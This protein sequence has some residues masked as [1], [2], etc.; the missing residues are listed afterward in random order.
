MNHTDMRK[1]I[2]YDSQSLKR[3]LCYSASPQA[4]AITEDMV[5][6]LCVNLLKFL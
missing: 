2:Y 6:H 1:E 5:N 4:I 3:I